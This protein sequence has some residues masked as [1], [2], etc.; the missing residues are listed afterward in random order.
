[1]HSTGP[2]ETTRDRPSSRWSVDDVCSETSTRALTFKFGLLCLDTN[3]GE[4]TETPSTICDG[5]PCADAARDVQRDLRRK[6][7]EPSRTPHP[8]RQCA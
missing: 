4:A 6:K 1:M 3:V 2:C 7:L 8:V 5:H